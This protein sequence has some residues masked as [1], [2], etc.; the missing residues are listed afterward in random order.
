MEILIEC[1]VLEKKM[2]SYFRGSEK[3]KKC[4]YNFYHHDFQNYANFEG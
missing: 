1:P 3:L 2:K 4:T